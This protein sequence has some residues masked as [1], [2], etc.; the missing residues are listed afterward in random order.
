MKNYYFIFSGIL[1]NV[2]QYGLNDDKHNLLK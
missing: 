2:I 1:V